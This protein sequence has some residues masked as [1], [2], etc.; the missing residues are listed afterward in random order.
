MSITVNTNLQALKIQQNLNNA[1]SKMNT[2]MERMSSGYKINSASDDAAGYAVS[3]RLSTTISSSKVA[4]DNVAIGANL[5]D[6]SEGSLNTIGSNLARIRDL[7]EEAATGTYSTKDVSAIVTEIMQ[8]VQEV[9]RS[10]NSATFNGINLFDSSSATTAGQAGIKLQ[11]GTTS[12]DTLTLDKNLFK[13]A[14]SSALGL[15]KVTDEGNMQ[16]KT[17]TGDNDW[18]NLT[19]KNGNLYNVKSATAEGYYTKVSTALT[20]MFNGTT[21]S[22]TT[23]PTSSTSTTGGTV[24]TTYSVATT[25]ITAYSASNFLNDADQAISNVTDRITKIGA[26]QNRLTSITNSLG[27]QETNLTAANSTIKDANVAEESAS[28]VQAQIL[29]SAS[30][31]LLVQANSAPQIALTLIKG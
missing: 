4:S 9:D 16:V 2:A 24:T 14:T 13:E 26:Y 31:T 23:A 20:A 6:T 25:A 21:Y 28:Y 5:L 1:T 8:R 3:T 18:A 17:G 7:S 11:I 27:T 29:Q 19:D 15:F 22:T 10:S 12:T 30:A